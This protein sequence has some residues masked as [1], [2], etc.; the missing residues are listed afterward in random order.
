MAGGASIIRGVVVFRVVVRHGKRNVGLTIA[1][2][3]GSMI[4]E[5]N[6]CRKYIH[7]SAE[8]HADELVICEQSRDADCARCLQVGNAYL[9]G[10]AQCASMQ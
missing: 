6:D 10:A 2:G 5:C 3:R 1:Q 7:D 8:S 4:V 9:R